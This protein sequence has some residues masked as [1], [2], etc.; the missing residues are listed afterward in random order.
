MRSEHNRSDSDSGS[1]SDL[2]RRSF[3]ERLFT[4][5]VVGALAPSALRALVLVPEVVVT[6]SDV[7]GLYTL[8]ISTIPDLAEIGGSVRITIPGIALS[9]RVIVTRVSEDRFEAVNARCPHQGYR[10]R[11]RQEGEDY[12]EC[13]A[14]YSHFAYDGTYISGPA[15]GKS[16]TRYET[17][18]DGETTLQIE[19]PGLASVGSGRGEGATIEL[20][21][22][23]PMH[24]AILFRLQLD[25]PQNL[26]LTIWSLDGREVAR[27]FEG[28]R[29]AG[30]WYIQADLSS[31]PSGP[32]LYRLEGDSGVLGSGKVVM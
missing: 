13:E 4:A 2:S 27:P 24:G 32:Y 17:I 20:H 18:Y 6:G 8:D 5:T 9:P 12:L 31:L 22:T 21:S 3:L 11:A 29:G 19:I 28:L 10:V 26:R 16:L 25:R 15:N 23:G 1:R 14:H 7:A 30:E